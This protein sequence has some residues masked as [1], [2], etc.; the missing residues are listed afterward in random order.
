MTHRD[1]KPSN[2]LIFPGNRIK[3]A[4]FGLA[5]EVNH[6]QASIS[7]GYTPLF[8]APEVVRLSIFAPI[9]FKN[10]VYSLGLSLC[11]LMIHEVPYF[12]EIQDHDIT[13]PTCYSLEIINFVYKLMIENP[14]ERPSIK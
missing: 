14:N 13:F 10:D 6:S 12:K 11:Y 4:D 1:L 5:K 8:A 7:S 9:P 2:I 3:I